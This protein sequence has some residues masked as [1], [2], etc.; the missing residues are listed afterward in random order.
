MGRGWRIGLAVAAVP[1]DDEDIARLRNPEQFH[2]RAAE[3]LAGLM[4]RRRGVRLERQ[5]R[6]RARSAANSSVFSATARGS[7]SKQSI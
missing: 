2:G 5:E 4:F 3:L 7:R 1:A 6:I